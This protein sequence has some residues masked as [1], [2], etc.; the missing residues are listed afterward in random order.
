MMKLLK[1]EYGSQHA[2]EHEKEYRP[3]PGK[4][5]TRSTGLSTPY[6]GRQLVH[7]ELFFAFKAVEEANHTSSLYKRTSLLLTFL[8][9][10]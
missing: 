5:L 10:I 7:Q 4:Q 1:T 6:D 2:G 9:K 8:L 3:G